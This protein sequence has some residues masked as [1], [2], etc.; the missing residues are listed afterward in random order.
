MEQAA[1]RSGSRE[2]QLLEGQRL[3][4]HILK[5]GTIFKFDLSITTVQ[6]ATEICCGEAASTAGNDNLQKAMVR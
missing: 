4:A 1:R 6:P 3:Q 2:G 5:E